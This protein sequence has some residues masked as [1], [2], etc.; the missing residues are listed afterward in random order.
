MNLNKQLLDRLIC[1]KYIFHKGVEI[2]DRGGPFS[3][4]LGVL[5]FQDAVEMVLR[6]VA[7][8]LHC[9]LKENAAFNQIIDLIDSS[10]SNKITHRSALN[11][12]NKARINF[13]HFGL[14]PKHEDVIKFRHDLEGFFP[15]VLKSFLDVDFFLISLTN[16][17]EHRRTENFLNKAEKLIQDMNYRD[18]ICSSAIAFAIF[19]SHHNKETDKYWRDPFRKV[20]DTEIKEWVESIEKLV[21]DQQAQLNLIMNGI[22]LSDYRKFQRCVPI[23]HLTVAG[24]YR[25]TYLGGWGQLE[26][27]LETALFCYNFVIDAILLMKANKLP[28]K[29]PVKESLQKIEVIKECPIIVWPGNEPEIIR[30]TEIGEIF[31]ARPERSDKA[32]H[33][34]I[35][36]DGDVAYIEK[37][38]ATTVK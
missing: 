12:L 8:H 30:V 36:L 27:S 24:T 5:H 21:L 18:S 29:Y 20:K 19:N 38:C 26:P 1:S 31:Y 35:I 16:L 17:I 10:G 32:A 33:I 13:K 25:V 6:I 14:E 22:N 28:S 34:A 2:L 37:A 4:G 23:V 15:N 3:S 11:Q 7:E 9:S